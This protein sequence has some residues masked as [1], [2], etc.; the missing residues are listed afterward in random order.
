M[1]ALKKIIP[2]CIEKDFTDVL[3]IN[4]DRGEPSILLEQ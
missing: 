4:E 1:A 3:V 2:Q